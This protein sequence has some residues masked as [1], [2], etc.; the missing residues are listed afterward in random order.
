MMRIR[1]KLNFYSSVIA[2]TLFVTTPPA[3]ATLVAETDGFPGNLGIGFSPDSGTPLSFSFTTDANDYT[4][5]SVTL[6]LGSTG[7]FGTAGQFS[8]A[9]SDDNFGTPGTLLELLAGSDTPTG[10]DTQYTYTGSSTLT[11]NTVYWITLA[12]PG[13]NFYDFWAADTHAESAGSV[14]TIGDDLYD[15]SGNSQGA[16]GPFASRFDATAIPSVPEPEVF[17]LMGPAII[18]LEYRKHKHP[19]PRNQEVST[20]PKT[21]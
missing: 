3:S 4:F 12:D 7:G 1:N 18:G 2:L 15:S 5:N 17:W 13:D 19:I 8:V 20:S 21:R 14:W 10:F 9:L 16:Q 11:S 6:I